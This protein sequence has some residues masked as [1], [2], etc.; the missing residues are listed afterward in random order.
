M[1][2]AAQGFRVA[3]FLDVEE[4][5]TPQDTV[6]PQ[7]L[8]AVRIIR[9]FTLGVM[10]AMNRRPLLGPHAGGQPQPE[11][12]EVRRQRRQIK[13]PVRLMAVQEDGD[14]SDG[15]VRESEEDQHVAPP[16]QINKTG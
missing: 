14:R 11:T 16:G 9:R 12:E 7:H 13:C 3:R 1:A 5:A 10:L 15:D 2:I 6:D 4:D 8:R